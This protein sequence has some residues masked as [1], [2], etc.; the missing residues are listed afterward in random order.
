MFGMQLSQNEKDSFRVCAA[1]EIQNGNI[2]LIMYISVAF[3][4]NE[5]NFKPVYLYTVNGS[6]FV[7]VF[8]SV[9]YLY[10]FSFLFEGRTKLPC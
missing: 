2:S 4:S 8:T 1:T 10:I 7:F 3:I 9:S 5:N 6:A